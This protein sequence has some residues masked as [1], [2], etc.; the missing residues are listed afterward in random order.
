VCV[1]FFLLFAGTSRGCLAMDCSSSSSTSSSLFLWVS[2][3]QTN[4]ISVHIF[5]LKS[6]KILLPFF[7]PS[8]LAHCNCF[9]LTKP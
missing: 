1:A 4:S 2:L 3:V 6:S 8:S 7:L 5:A 9:Q